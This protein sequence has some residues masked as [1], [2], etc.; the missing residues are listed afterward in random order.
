MSVPEE[1]RIRVRNT[2]SLGSWRRQS[3]SDD[4]IATLMASKK[5]KNNNRD[6][7]TPASAPT[8][9]PV[10][11]AKSRKKLVPVGI[12][13]VCAALAFLL[14]RLWQPGI[15]AGAY[16]DYNVLFITIDTL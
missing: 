12:L 15:R 9:Q 1:P 5:K 3:S 13:I 6:N 10:I 14:W 8:P 2:Q 7:E 4:G 16:K 11:G